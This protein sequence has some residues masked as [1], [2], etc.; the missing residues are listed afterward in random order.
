MQREDQLLYGYVTHN[1]AYVYLDTLPIFLTV[2]RLLESAIS[3]I[4]SSLPCTASLWRVY[5]EPSDFFHTL[6]SRLFS[7]GSSKSNVGSQHSAPA[8][9]KDAQERQQKKKRDPYSIG[10]PTTTNLSQTHL[11]SNGYADIEL[12]SPKHGLVHAQ[13][14]SAGTATGLKE[15]DIH[16]R[17]SVEQLS[18][19]YPQSLELKEE[20]TI[21]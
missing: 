4:L 18:V 5:I 3:V 8:F 16:Q 14:S 1:C 15:G 17:L 20:N 12:T 7:N 19:T 9:I 6:R 21:V 11:S 10:M 13:V 2:N